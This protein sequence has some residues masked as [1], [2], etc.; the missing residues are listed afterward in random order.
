MKTIICVLIGI[1]I[2]SGLSACPL[3]AEKYAVLISAGFTTEEN[4][5]NNSEFW[6]DLLL[7]YTTLIDY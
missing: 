3:R 6:Y 4:A 1:L 7:M 2:L 5:V